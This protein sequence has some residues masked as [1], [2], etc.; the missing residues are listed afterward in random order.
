MSLV[1]E[2]ESASVRAALGAADARLALRDAIREIGLRGYPRE[3]LIAVL[4]ELA[5]EYRAKGEAEHLATVVEALDLL[6]GNASP[7]AVR[8]YFGYSE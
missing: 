5:D 4:D 2:R 6:E 3:S 7:Y 8:S 1:M